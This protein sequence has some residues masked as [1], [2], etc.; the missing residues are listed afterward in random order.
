MNTLK[1]IS[2]MLLLSLLI[3][4]GCSTKQEQVYQPV[5][6]EKMIISFQKMLESGVTEKYEIFS[7]GRYAFSLLNKNNEEN[8]R[9]NTLLP[10][11]LTYLK[12]LVQGD[13]FDS[14]PPYMEGSGE[15]CPILLL[16]INLNQEVT[17]RAES[18]ANTPEAFNKILEEIEKLK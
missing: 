4:T 7:T 9:E 17:K 1:Y 13:K 8:K 3:V 10:E 16:R 14:I 11:D 15:N 18:C 12:S 5:E 2:I 6:E